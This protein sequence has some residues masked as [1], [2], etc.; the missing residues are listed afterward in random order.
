[1]NDLGISVIITLIDRDFGLHQRKK[2]CMVN[3]LYGGPPVPKAF[4]IVDRSERRK[5]TLLAVS[6]YS[7]V[8]V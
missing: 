7:T 4:D 6:G 1:M 5:K 2:S 3:E 8:P